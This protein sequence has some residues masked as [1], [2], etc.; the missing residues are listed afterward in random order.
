MV[1]QTKI[2]RSLDGDIAAAQNAAKETTEAQPGAE[3]G[4]LPIKSFGR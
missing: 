2:S 1:M 3:N 4:Y